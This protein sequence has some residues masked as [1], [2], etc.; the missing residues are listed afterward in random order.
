MAT[1]QSKLR[2]SGIEPTVSIK[3][4]KNGNNRKTPSPLDD[5][6]LR[7]DRTTCNSTIYT[8]LPGL[9]VLCTLYLIPAALLT[10]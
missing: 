2:Y 9:L 4:K 5:R 10:R 8:I 7:L 1:K 6:V 3:A